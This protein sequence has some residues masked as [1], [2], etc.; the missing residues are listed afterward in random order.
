MCSLKAWGPKMPQFHHLGSATTHWHRQERQGYISIAVRCIIMWGKPS[1]MIGSLH[2]STL[3]PEVGIDPL[4][5]V[6]GCPCDRV[7]IK[8]VLNQLCMQS[9][10]PMKS[11]CWCTVAYRYIYYA[12]TWPPE[13]SGGLRCNSSSS[14]H[15]DSCDTGCPTSC[16]W[17]IKLR[18]NTNLSSQWC[19]FFTLLSVV[20]VLC[21]AEVY[22]QKLVSTWLLEQFF[23]SLPWLVCCVAAC[24][25]PLRLLHPWCVKRLVTQA[26]WGWKVGGYLVSSTCAKVSIAKLCLGTYDSV[27]VGVGGGGVFCSSHSIKWPL[28]VSQFVAFL[29]CLIISACW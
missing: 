1:A 19:S 9:F 2:K 28:E 15:Q 26:A 29:K 11:I 18:H 12:S 24:V 25:R 22:G 27:A 21:Q 20:A 5:M 16:N 3:L 23:P 7:I 10:H 8:N 14:S 13:C 4:K 6:C 17:F